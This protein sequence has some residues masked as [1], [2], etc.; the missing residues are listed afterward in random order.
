MVF[1]TVSSEN[2]WRKTM[3]QDQE[4]LEEIENEFIVTP[5]ELEMKFIICSGY[6]LWF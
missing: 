1:L 5:S 6:F 2:K 3:C 4:K